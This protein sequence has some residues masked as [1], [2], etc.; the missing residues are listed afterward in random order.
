MNGS[1]RNAT[2]V[3]DVSRTTTHKAAPGPEREN[4][5]LVFS[6]ICHCTRSSSPTVRKGADYMQVR[7]T[8]FLTVGL[9]FRRYRTVPPRWRQR[10]ECIPADYQFRNRLALRTTVASI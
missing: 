4:R 9:L 7:S 2:K 8:P 1:N 5:S 6:L 3:T 10:V